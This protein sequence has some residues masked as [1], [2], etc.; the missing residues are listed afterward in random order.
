MDFLDGWYFLT[1][2]VQKLSEVQ[3]APEKRHS[4]GSVSFKF[5]DRKHGT[6]LDKAKHAIR[7]RQDASFLSL[8]PNPRNFY[9]SLLLH[10]P[11][12]TALHERLEIS[13]NSPVS[14]RL[15]HVLGDHNS[16]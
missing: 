10:R 7:S 8:H 15:L 13:E 2:H 9:I 3:L 11:P 12:S 16:Q 4:N 6:S 14:H 1:H 5:L